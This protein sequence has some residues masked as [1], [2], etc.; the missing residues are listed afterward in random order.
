MN[1]TIQYNNYN[2]ILLE[3]CPNEDFRTTGFQHGTCPS[4]IKYINKF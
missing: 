1:V 2:K 3:I 4:K